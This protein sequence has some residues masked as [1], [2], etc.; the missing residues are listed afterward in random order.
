MLHKIKV[1][2]ASEN[3]MNS[4]TL[5]LLSL[6]CLFLSGMMSF[7]NYTQIGW[8]WNT[9]V[10]F[11]PNFI[12]T[13]MAIFLIAPLYMR[14]ILKWN[15]S[16]YSSIAFILIL[17]VFASFVQLALGGNGKN[18]IITLLLSAAVV[19]SWLGI[20]PIAG[21]AWMLVF[22]AGIYSAIANSLAMGFF[23]F[24][25]VASGFYRIGFSF[26]AKSWSTC[27]RNKE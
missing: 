9:T 23:G 18:I 1:A 14:E 2:I 20:K 3:E 16:I 15:K 12:S 24:I 19:L 10:S 5:R 13:I 6:F 11:S 25:Y 22:T 8:L 4:E 7:F 17:L 27:S 21:V 26:R